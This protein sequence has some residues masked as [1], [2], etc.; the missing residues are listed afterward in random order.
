MAASTQHDL[1]A[2]LAE[3]KV[4]I[5]ALEAALS[6]KVQPDPLTQCCGFSIE[7]LA[8]KLEEVYEDHFEPKVKVRG[9]YMTP[10]TA[11]FVWSINHAVFLL[12]K[13]ADEVEDS[14]WNCSCATPEMCR[15]DCETTECYNEWRTEEEA[16]GAEHRLPVRNFKVA[17]KS[18]WRLE[19][20][21]KKAEEQWDIARRRYKNALMTHCEDPSA[22]EHLASL[23]EEED[24]WEKEIE[25]L[26]EL[27]DE[28][29]GE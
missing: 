13:E 25:R 1:E 24:W 16:K 9:I 7:Q 14:E 21:I 22:D 15:H 17:I 6:A 23:S 12:N 4:R 27:R 2:Q 19:R 28:R 11:G 20:N 8:E 26:R 10:P 3:A 5:A 29:A 18:G